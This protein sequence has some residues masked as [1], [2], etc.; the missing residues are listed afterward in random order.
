[1]EKKIKDRRFGDAEDKGK[2]GRKEMPEG[3]RRRR[4]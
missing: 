3:G 2:K 4:R 1:M